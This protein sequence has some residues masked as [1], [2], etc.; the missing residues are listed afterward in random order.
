MPADHQPR[1]ASLA[2]LS[3]ETTIELLQLAKDGDRV[4]LD[5][6][7]E[8]CMPRLRRWAHGRLPQWA[9]G[10]LETSDLVQ[11]ALISAMGRLEVFE[12]RHQGALQAYLRQAV[13]NHIRDVLRQQGRRGYHVELPE[14]L[15]DEGTSPLER[16]IGLQ[17][18]ERY[19]HALARLRPADREAIIGRLELQQS[20]EELAT[21]LDKST[22]DAARIAVAR[23]MKRLAEEMRRG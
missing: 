10:V 19:D 14:D 12:S 17:N 22:P 3:A 8:R 16:V 7:L 6:L 15:K 20:Y 21:A 5:R 18:A 11:D 2:P 13:L 23:A 9:R 4:A 1:G